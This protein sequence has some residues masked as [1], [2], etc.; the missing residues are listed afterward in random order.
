MTILTGQEIAIAIVSVAV[1]LTFLLIVITRRK[2]RAFRSVLPRPEARSAFASRLSQMFRQDRGVNVLLSELEQVLLE[3]D[4]G[5]RLTDDLIARLRALPKEKTPEGF[6]RALKI[7]LSSYVRSFPS[8]DPRHGPMVFLILGVNGAGKTTTIAKLAHFWKSRGKQV[9]VIAGDT[10]RAA[11]I[12]Q[13]KVWGERVG[14]EVVAQTPGADPGAVLYDGLSAAK[15]RAADVVLVDTAGR[16]H[17]KK[18]LLDELSKLDRVMGKFALQQERYLVLDATMGQN[19]LAQARVFSEALPVDAAI[20]TKW[21]GSAKGGVLFAIGRELGL[22]VAFVG[23]GEGMGD[24][25][26]FDPEQFITALFEA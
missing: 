4:L 13:L 2:R 21:D 16:L 12:E 18:P 14:F 23:V 8:P 19:G 25:E 17:T 24:L 26:P 22:P 5:P 20:L 15:A 10:F 3:A 11:A 9:M 7:A 1:M 6:K